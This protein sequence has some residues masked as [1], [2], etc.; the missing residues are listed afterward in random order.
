MN[1][2]SRAALLLAAALVAPP[3]VASADPVRDWNAIMVATVSGQNPFA[4]AR[5]AAITQ[6]AVFEAVNAITGAYEPYCG[7]ISAPPGA[8][9]EA[10]SV[11]AAHAVL[12]T[13]F[14]ASSASLDV[15]RATSLASIPDGQ[16][17]VDGIAVG[18][19]AA[20]AM[21]A[22][23]SDDGSAPPRF[24]LPASSD[25]GVWQPTP[26]CPPAGGVL[27]AGATWRRSRSGAPGRSARSR[28]RRSR[29]APTPATSRR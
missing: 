28:P 2:T 3:L 19:A 13:C 15:A 24:H 20:A 5:F 17:E 18:E 4:Q 21:I 16:A 7:T 10:P 27:L 26:S 25:P 29:A 9:P 6:L 22:A 8:S 1:D 23:R 11:A 12:R 14:P